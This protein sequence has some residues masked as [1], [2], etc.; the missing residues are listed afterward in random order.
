M[1]IKLI[2]NKL[3]DN[4]AVQAAENPRRRI[5]Y[6]FH[7]ALSDPINRML[8]VVM[9]DTYLPPHRHTNP[10]KDEIFLILRGSVLVFLF[11]DEGNVIFTKEINP[12][13]GVYGMDFNSAIWHSFVV[14]EDATAMY[15]VKEGP[16]SPLIPEDLAPWAPAANDKVAAAEYIQSLRKLY[17]ISN[18]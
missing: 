13:K 4:V 17:M 12:A 9:K 18:Q 15:E 16:Y 5:N 10:V 7:K 14:L 2:D 11:D 3:L 8:N 6:N 1:N